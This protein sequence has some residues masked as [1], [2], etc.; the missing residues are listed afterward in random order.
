M[1][2][3]IIFLIGILFL[4]SFMIYEVFKGFL[5]AYSNLSIKDDM[6]LIYITILTKDID[7]EV[8]L[9]YIRHRQ[10]YYEK[11]ENNNITNK[12]IILGLL[13][14]VIGYSNIVTL[15]IMFYIFV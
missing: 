10:L 1:V 12:K 5:L 14:L 11:L 3:N 6:N 7:K 2:S 15:V 9:Q 4:I 8:S 13:L